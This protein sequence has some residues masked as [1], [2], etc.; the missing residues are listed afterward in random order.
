MS[1][2]YAQQ[3][4]QPPR[5]PQVG[6]MQD[7]YFAMANG[8]PGPSCVL[9]VNASNVC[10]L[11]GGWT[12][13]ANPSNVCYC[14]GDLQLGDAS[15]PL[16]ISGLV[17][18]FVQGTTHI[19]NS[20]QPATPN[21]DWMAVVSEGDIQIDSPPAP[22]AL[23]INGTF[24]TDGS[25]IVQGGARPLGQL[26]FNGGIISQNKIALAAY[27]LSRTYTYHAAD[28]NLKLPFLIEPV[29]WTIRHGKNL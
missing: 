13:T 1:P 4:P 16:T 20:I 28:P 17:V 11:N 15:G 25:M 26:T 24:I 7:S 12:A 27:Q 10:L 2:A 8:P 23:T 6:P 9:P 22:D 18:I 29:S 14:A 5:L 3:L 21:V 19:Q